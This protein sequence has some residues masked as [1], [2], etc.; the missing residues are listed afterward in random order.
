M[1]HRNSKTRFS[2][3]PLYNVRPPELLPEYPTNSIWVSHKISIKFEVHNIIAREATHPQRAVG[4]DA[5]HVHHGWL[6][7]YCGVQAADSHQMP[8]LLLVLALQG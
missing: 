8:Q 5:G 1:K 3:S 6:V 4:C 2:T 7:I